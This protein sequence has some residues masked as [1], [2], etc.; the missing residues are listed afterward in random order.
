MISIIIPV[1]RLDKINNLVKMIKDKAGLDC[2]EYEI[3][4]KYDE[5]RIG[6][7][8][9]VKHLTDISNGDMVCFLGDDTLPQDNFLSEA[10]KEM[11]KFKDGWGLVGL[12]DGTGRIDLPC[13][14]LAHKKLL[15]YLENKE[16]FYTGYTHCYCD[17]ELMDKANELGRYSYCLSSLVL[18]DHPALTGKPTDDPDYCRVYKPA[19]REKDMNLYYSRK[20]KKEVLCKEIHCPR[21]K[22][23]IG[24]VIE[25]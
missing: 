10:L 5:T 3:I 19:I 9:M 7:P 13:H 15:D 14:W 22:L 20:L 12:N 18:H 16:F 17:K 21:C 8:K 4:H 6:C 1:V 25:K 24:M 11:Q 2:N 23:Q